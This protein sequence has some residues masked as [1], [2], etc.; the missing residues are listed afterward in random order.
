MSESAINGTSEVASAVVAATLTTI[1]VFFP[2]VFISGIAGQLFRDQA[3]TVTFAL[4]FSLIVALTVIPMLSSLGAGSRY[5]DENENEPPGRFTRL[6]A[7]IVRASGFAFHGVRW[8][9]WAILWLPTQLFQR[10]YGAAAAVYPALLRWSL[11]HRATVVVSALLIFAGSMALVPRL[12]TELIPQLS[13][14]EFDVDLRLA[15]RRHRWRRRIVP[16]RQR[17]APPR[18]IDTVALDYSVAG[19]GNRLDANP[20]DAGDNTG[21]LSIALVPGAG[22]GEENAAM[23]AMRRNLRASPACSTSS[24]G[25]P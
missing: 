14:G 8:L 21:T 12:G 4:V 24:A 3:L 19:T 1:A 15:A 11:R 7:A 16:S 13:Q 6:V 10:L 18:D 17:R 22:R 23:E 9:F 2:M 20:V 5:V 25:Q